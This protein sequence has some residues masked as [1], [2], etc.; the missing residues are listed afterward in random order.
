MYFGVDIQTDKTS[1]SHVVAHTHW[2]L[3]VSG[4]SASDGDSYACAHQDMY[5]WSG[6]REIDQ[7][8]MID[9]RQ[10]DNSGTTSC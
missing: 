1:W 10:G 6:Q 3:P 2:R 8:M 4:F 5:R 7:E 9:R